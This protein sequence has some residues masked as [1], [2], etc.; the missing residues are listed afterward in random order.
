MTNSAITLRETGTRGA[1]LEA[2]VS[3]MRPLTHALA[4]AALPVLGWS[5]PSGLPGTLAEAQ[6]DDR[7]EQS[8]C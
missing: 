4:L 2:Q 6:S 1:L 5:R 3:P 7:R 8:L